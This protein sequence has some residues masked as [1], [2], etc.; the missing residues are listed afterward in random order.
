MYQTMVNWQ[1]YWTPKG[2]T[3]G[4]CLTKD[5]WPYIYINI[6]KNSS[7]W[8]SALLAHWCL[9]QRDN[10]FNNQDLQNKTP[11]IILRDP[12]SRWLSGIGEY[13]NLYHPGT[14]LNNIND[15][16]L[17]WIFDRVAFDDHTEQQTMFIQNINYN[18]AIWF[19]S[20]DSLSTNFTKWLYS[21]NELNETYIPS[22]PENTTQSN[23]S[24]IQIK[25]FFKSRLDSNPKWQYKIRQYFADDYKLIQ[26]VKFYQTI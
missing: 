8:T 10:Y 18:N 12:A 14:N 23:G 19:Y 7:S 1:N 4:Q 9:C 16:M 17:E 21:I 11:V 5:Q 15:T 6:P 22:P 24:K 25:Q 20:D 26:E 13:I 3:Y 2:H